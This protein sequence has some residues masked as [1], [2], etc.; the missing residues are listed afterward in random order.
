MFLNVLQNDFAEL[1]PTGAI[2][3]NGRKA[4]LQNSLVFFSSVQTVYNL[5]VAFN[6]K[7]KQQQQ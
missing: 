5:S 2:L 7:K 6:L 3:P 1:P 4:C